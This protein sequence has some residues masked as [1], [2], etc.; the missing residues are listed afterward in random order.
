M[1]KIEEYAGWSGLAGLPGTDLSTGLG[2][3][4]MGNMVA[5]LRSFGVLPSSSKTVAVLKTLG[6][7]GDLYGGCGGV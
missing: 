7:L 5:G 3:T 2:A 4:G 1:V 6:A